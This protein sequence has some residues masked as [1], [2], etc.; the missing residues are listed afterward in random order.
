MHHRNLAGTGGVCEA[1]PR[2]QMPASASGRRVR[3]GWEVT[4]VY[5]IN[6]MVKLVRQQ[7]GMEC[8]CLMLGACDRFG[9]LLVYRPLRCPTLSLMELADPVS[10]AG[11]ESSRLMVLGDFSI[12]TG[13]WRIDQSR[14]SWLL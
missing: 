1:L 12:H 5:R 9:L 14:T 3:W 13:P 11:L 6:L 10:E 7:P 8:L 2:F 4:I